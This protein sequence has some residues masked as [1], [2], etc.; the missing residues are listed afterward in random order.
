M[1]GGNAKSFIG[2]SSFEFLA[3]FQRGL[4]YAYRRRYAWF[5][6]TLFLSCGLPGTLFVGPL[7]DFLIS[8][9]YAEAYAYRLSFVFAT[10]L[11]LMELVVQSAL[12]YFARYRS[13]LKCE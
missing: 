6:A 7:V 5:N 12:I 9:D 1:S 2:L 3:M 4:F 11:V 8:R 13:G 10:G